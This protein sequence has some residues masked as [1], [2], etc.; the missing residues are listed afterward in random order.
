[1]LQDLRRRDAEIVR[2]QVTVSKTLDRCSEE[3]LG[4]NIQIEKPTF[5]EP[6]QLC[7]NSGLADTTDTSEEYAHVAT[8][9]EDCASLGRACDSR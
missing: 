5:K 9:D 7:A 4:F 3:T 2:R 8:F 6:S 1:V